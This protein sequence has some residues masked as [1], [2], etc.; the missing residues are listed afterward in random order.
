MYF[1]IFL[2]SNAKVHL[3]ISTYNVIL[4]RIAKFRQAKVIYKILDFLKSI[5]VNLDGETYI[6]LLDLFMGL[7]NYKK[8][9]FYLAEVY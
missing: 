3:N 8:V 1:L 9:A 2:D 6:I 5:K 4:K 7:N